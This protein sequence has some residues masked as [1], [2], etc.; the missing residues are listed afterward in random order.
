[1]KIHEVVDE[2]FIA[3][4]AVSGVNTGEKSDVCEGGEH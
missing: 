1:M 2:S 3:E 4:V